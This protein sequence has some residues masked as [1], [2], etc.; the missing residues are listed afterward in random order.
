MATRTASVPGES[1]SP[2]T[3]AE[4]ARASHAE[5]EGVGAALSLKDLVRE[6]TLALERDLILQA[7]ESCSWNVTRTAERLGLSRK[8]LQ[9][10]M[11]ELDIRK[12]GS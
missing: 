8:G 4:V 7:F 6:R 9:V 10:K 5:R 11:K 12:P 1:A 3:H 2:S